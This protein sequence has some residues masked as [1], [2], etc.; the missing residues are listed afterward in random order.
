MS[1]QTLTDTTALLFPDQ[2]EMTPFIT[3]SLMADFSFHTQPLL[4]EN[5]H[6]VVL[7]ATTMSSVISDIPGADI[8]LNRHSLL[9]R[10][11][12]L[13]TSSTSAPTVVSRGTQEVIE[14]Y[15]AASLISR[16]EHWRLLSSS[17]FPISPAKIIIS[18][19]VAI[20]NSSTLYQF[21][22]QASIPSE[23]HIITEASSNRRLTNIK[24]QAADSLSELSQACATCSLTE[25]KSSHEFPDQVLHSKQSHFYETFW[26]NS[27]ILASWYA[28]MGPQTITSG[29]SF[30]FATEITPS[31]AFAELP[32][33]FPSKMSTERTILPS[34]LEES[35][36]PSSN[37]DV[38][39]CLDKTCLSIVPSQTVSSDLIHSDLTSKLTTVD[40]SVSENISKL[41]KIGQYGVTMGPTE[42]LNEYTLL[43]MQESEGFHKPF[44][45]HTMDRSLDFK[46]NSKSHP[47]VTLNINLE[48]IHPSDLRYNLPSYIDSMS[49]VSEVTSNVAFYSVS[50]TPS[51]PIP[52]SFPKSVVIP[53][54]SYYT[55]YK[56]SMYDLTEEVRT[57]L[58]W[59]KWEL[60]TSVRD[61]E[62]T[63]RQS[64]SFTGCLTLSSLEPIPAPLQLMITGE[65]LQFLFSKLLEMS[66]LFFFSFPHRAERAF[67]VT[68]YS[69]Q[70]YCNQGS[71]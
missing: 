39:L 5:Y 27:A 14:E 56:T 42:L 37:L 55:D 54:W 61:L 19:Q 41:F 26:M 2:I 63:T 50:P 9:S 67:V 32:S 12:L 59:S 44:K 40:S 48:T 1:D 10:G 52:M 66:F 3:S 18:K 58:Q 16:R 22:T 45:L 34:S 49:D 17:M 25:I 68:R 6:T 69:K 43:D 29:H 4:F 36:T 24:S 28:L 60:W 70:S 62:S 47:D 51:L 13:T 64:L 20:L 8:K 38:N 46:L 31:V 7:S 53:D 21:S 57:S 15:S 65:F 23:Y 30:S 11:F 35:I 33:L 71:S